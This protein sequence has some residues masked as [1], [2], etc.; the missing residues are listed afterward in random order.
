M[1]KRPKFWILAGSAI[2]ATLLWVSNSAG[3]IGCQA[4]FVIG[5]RI[6]GGGFGIGTQVVVPSIEVG[7]MPK[8][9][10]RI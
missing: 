2:L 7:K 10:G 9:E 4:Q 6:I 5:D 3:N 1:L 8:A